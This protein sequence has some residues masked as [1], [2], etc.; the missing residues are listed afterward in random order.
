MTR[1]SSGTTRA[2]STA[3]W[4]DS[5]LE[6]APRPCR[7][8]APARSGRPERDGRSDATLRSASVSLVYSRCPN[9]SR[10]P[11]VLLRVDDGSSA[12]A[13][14]SGSRRSRYRGA[15]RPSVS[16]DDE[17]ADHHGVL[18]RALAL[19]ALEAGQHERNPLEHS[20]PPFQ[21]AAR[22]DPALLRLTQLS[23]VARAAPHREGVG[24]ATPSAQLHRRQ[25]G[26]NRGV[27]DYVEITRSRR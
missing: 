20:L 24:G 8:E 7:S 23:H 14:R 6:E 25:A 1:R 18:S 21:L 16:A 9:S 10:C 5:L 19:L 3:D 2:N 15:P 13:T 22:R 17:E 26:D 12:S 27:A 11:T 4:P